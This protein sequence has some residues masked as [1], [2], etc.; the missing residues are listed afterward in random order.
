MEESLKV[1]VR[2]IVKEVYFTHLEVNGRIIANRLFD[3]ISLAIA[4]ILVGK[5]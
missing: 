5:R 4:E 2:N 1:K 3:E